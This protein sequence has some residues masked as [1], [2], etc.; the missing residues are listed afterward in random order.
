MTVSAQKQ[1]Q[2]DEYTTTQLSKHTYRSGVQSKTELHCET[3]KTTT[4]T[5]IIF[6]TKVPM[7][8]AFFTDSNDALHSVEAAAAAA[9]NCMSLHYTALTD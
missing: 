4:T 7:H 9:G 3:V 5:S 6:Y 2:H 8:G 1:C